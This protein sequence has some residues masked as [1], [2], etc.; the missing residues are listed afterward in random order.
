ML[1]SMGRGCQKHYSKQRHRQSRWD[2]CAPSIEERKRYEIA[3]T[4]PDAMGRARNVALGI[5]HFTCQGARVA[6]PEMQSDP[7]LPP[8]DRFLGFKWGGTNAPPFQ[9]TPLWP[10]RGKKLGSAGGVAASRGFLRCDRPARVIW[11]GPTVW[12]LQLIVQGLGLSCSW[13]GG[14]GAS[15]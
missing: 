11:G 14:E 9:A 8:S 7:D 5:G 4:S 3:K 6:H 12:Q 2:R 1:K 10:W 15:C 13:E